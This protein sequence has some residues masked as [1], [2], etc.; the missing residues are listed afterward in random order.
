MKTSGT[1]RREMMVATLGVGLA[2]LLPS[3][4]A[5]QSVGSE[6]APSVFETAGQMH[7][8]A[9]AYL[10]EILGKDRPETRDGLYKLV[11]QLRDH[12]LI[13]DSEVQ[14]LHELI[15][16]LYSGI[17]LEKIEAKARGLLET[18]RAKA[19]DLTITLV[20]ITLS[21]IRYV[22]KE[23]SENKR[24]IFVISSD[25]AGGLQGAAVS[26]EIGPFFAAAAA[27]TAATAGSCA[28]WY[29]SR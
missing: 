18:A 29:A 24:A 10:R 2:A 4:S 22:R 5:Q 12:H 8:K 15:D 13:D 17:E 23:I 26:W 7:E 28:A 27:L 19:K 11:R 25:L 1:S 21:S 9:V 6:P 20:S 16:A 14:L 3:A